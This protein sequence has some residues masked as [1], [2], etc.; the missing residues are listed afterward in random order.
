MKIGLDIMG[1]DFAPD[2]TVAGAL[3]AQKELP[4]EVQIVLIGKE[5]EIRS[6]VS[7]DLLNGSSLEIV[8][9]RDV[10][11]MG[12]SP[13]KALSQKRNSS[14]SVGFRMLKKKELDGF[15]STGNSGA[16]LVGAMQS[17][18]SIPGIYRPCITTPFP[19]MN[20]SVT[21]LLDVGI[22]ADC[23][24]DVLYQF[25]ILGSLYAQNVYGIDNPRVG[26]LNIGE[27]EKKGNLLTQ[28]THEMMKGTEDFNF[29]GNVEGRDIFNEEIDVIVCDGFT[30]NVV[31]K[32]AEAFYA[33]IKKRG[34]SDE[35][36]DKFNYENYGGTPFLGINAPVVIGH[37]SSNDIAIKNMVMLTKEIVDAQLSTKIMEALLK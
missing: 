22:N 31:L 32:E 15:A 4:P 8:D 10:V 16:M 19:K 26:L 25:A 7:S 37:G 36:F 18:G 21:I 5:D 28:A 24:P 35:Y 2:T 1:G 11:E 33:A 17:V 20:G 30:G 6:R 34:I 23:K 9:A 27:E 12:D 3:L 13:T 29:V 14:I